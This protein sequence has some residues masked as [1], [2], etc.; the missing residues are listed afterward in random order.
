MADAYT[1][2]GASSLDQTAYDLAMHKALRPELY[3]DALA[4]V[5]ATNQSFPGA[6]VTFTFNVDLSAATA[7]LNESTD[8]D[9]V[10]MSDSVVTATLLEKGNAVITTA[11]LRGSSFIPFDPIVADT[12]GFNA[13]LSLDTIARATLEAG[14]NVRYSTG[15]GAAPAGRSSVTPLNTIRATDVRRAVVDLKDGFSKP[16][17][18]YYVAVIHPDVSFDLRSETGNSAVW[19]DPH[20]YSEPANIWSGEIGV[21]EGVRFI[22][23][24]RG[25]LFADAGSSA[26]TTDVY[27]TIFMG[28]EALGKAYS[29]TD[30]NGPMPQL[31]AGAVVDK[32]R[33]N[34]P[35]G[36]YWFGAYVRFRE[37]CIRRVE[38]ASSIG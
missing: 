33:R 36:W 3:F 26:T 27:A 18:G 17:N 22:E 25:S 37:A 20:T 1:G 6:A 16:I 32:L 9:A 4:T 34:Q 8:V 11:K 2:V 30:G 13:G 31:V 7:T 5:R 12:V 35:M 24:P 19:R 38:Q 10:A 28:Q 15:T 29:Y 21:F 23:T 14:S